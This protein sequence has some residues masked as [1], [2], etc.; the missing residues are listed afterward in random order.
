M[1]TINYKNECLE[2]YEKLIGKSFDL[3]SP[4]RSTIPLLAYWANPDTRLADF[5]RSLGLPFS[6]DSALTFEYMVFPFNGRGKASHTDLMVVSPS[7]A[8]AIEAKY[9][10]P[11]YKTVS[12]WLG[13]PPEENR[14]LVLD[15][16]LDVIS[17][18]TGCSVNIQDISD[19]SYQLIHRTASACQP[20]AE[21]R[22]VVYHC[23]VDAVSPNQKTD[24]DPERHRRYADELRNLA[25]LVGAND[26]LMFFLYKTTI[27]KTQK[28]SDLQEIW[29]GQS[30]KQDVSPDVR[31]LLREGKIAMFS[32]PV[33]DQF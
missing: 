9:T 32:D 4:Y 25:R 24:R 21:R 33:V 13:N 22:A 5:Q 17:K 30:P 29:R 2:S 6:N 8:I 3:K 18:I 27:N 31:I 20:T 10:E 28:F 15:G 23:F 11:L 16:W 14:K 19:F 1:V 26:R 12:A 7:L